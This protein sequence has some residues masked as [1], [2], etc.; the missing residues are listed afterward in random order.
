MVAALLLLS[1]IEAGMRASAAVAPSFVV[2]APLGAQTS[3]LMSMCGASGT[4]AS[5]M[6]G[7]VCSAHC[8]V[9]SGLLPIEPILPAVARMCP[10]PAL[11][12]AQEDHRPSPDPHPPK[13]TFLA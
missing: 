1:G 8:A 11:A 2:A 5:S 7:M 3:R 4:Q 6:T 12:L 9:A 13:L 10:L